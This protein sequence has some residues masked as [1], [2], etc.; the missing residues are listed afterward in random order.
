MNDPESLDIYQQRIAEIQDVSDVVAVAN[1]Q[2]NKILQRFG[3]T[4][5]SLHSQDQLKVCPIDESHNVKES[6]MSQH[7]KIC[8]ARKNKMLSI[9]PTD[10][11][12]PT[13]F[14]YE[15]TNIV[16]VNLGVE[17]YEAIGVNVPGQK[18][19]SSKK[20]QRRSFLNIKSLI[21][22][23]LDIC[24]YKPCDSLDELRFIYSWKKIPSQYFNPD[25]SLIDEIILKNWLTE[26]IP[27]SKDT[28][29]DNKQSI[30]TFV[31]KNLSKTGNPDDFVQILLPVMKK[32]T[33]DFV[34]QLWKFLCAKTLCH[35][36]Q[37]PEHTR[38]EFDH[39]S[40]A[41][42]KAKK[43]SKKVDVI[44]DKVEVDTFSILPNE[45]TLFQLSRE[46]RL[47][48]YEKAIEAG[49]ILSDNECLDF[50]ELK[51]K[52]EEQMKTIREFEEQDKGEKTH[53]QVMAEIRDYKRRRQ[54]YRGKNKDS[55]KMT[56]LEVL[57]E[58]VEQQML[59]L[60]ILHQTKKAQERAANEQTESETN[61]EKTEPKESQGRQEKDSRDD[62]RSRNR[63]RS[64][65]RGR[66]SSAQP[67]NHRYSSS[68]STTQRSRE[69]EE[70]YNRQHSSSSSR[71][72]SSR[73]RS[74]SRERRHH[75]ST[76]RDR[77]RKERSRNRTDK[78]KEV[79]NVTYY[80]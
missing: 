55:R 28:G 13:S 56:G 33:I 52:T 8:N 80:D 31:T 78:D 18:S 70:R 12:E 65:S 46:Q 22:D 53:L 11:V 21:E 2:L 61:P 30:V 26:N 29:N 42:M 63:S 75:R 34:L 27:S 79:S 69:K 64:R 66:E 51:A 43:E 17:D 54:T 48:I 3:W 36:Q 9:R 71:K 4:K 76:S 74:R 19:S 45:W 15:G 39:Y 35:Q 60:E 14:F 57:R 58:L 67:R 1:L 32:K 38:N 16:S 41:T 37:I 24:S 6:N 20:P 72:L 73:H 44:D 40:S 23:D 62:N 50:N 5:Q 47:K 25:I 59:Y 68:S 7:V 10:F 77:V 49:K